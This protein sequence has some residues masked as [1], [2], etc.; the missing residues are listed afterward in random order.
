MTTMDPRPSEVVAGSYVGDVNDLVRAAAGGDQG[1]W[2][3][4]VERYHRLVWAVIRSYRLDAADAADVSQTTWLRLV[5]HLGSLRD[6]DRV[7]AWL[8]TTA[9]REALRLARQRRAELDRVSGDADLQLLPS[10]V[11]LIEDALLRSEDDAALWRALRQLDDRCQRLLR[12]LA[13]AP[14]PRYDEIA[15]ALG[16]PVGSI[17][18]TRGRCLDRLRK[19]LLDA[20]WAGDVAT[21]EDAL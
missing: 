17:G 3:G 5:E 13:A 2:D 16:M 9:R 20:G 12:C 7:G 6:P 10:A 11:P 14:P 15:D 18:P 21:R 8:A 19:F 1:A 4:L